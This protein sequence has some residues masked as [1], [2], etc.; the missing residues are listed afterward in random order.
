[1]C[2]VLLLSPLYLMETWGAKQNLAVRPVHPTTTKKSTIHHDK[3]KPHPQNHNHNTHN[4]ELVTLST[5][6]K[7]R[8]G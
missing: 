1:M 7:Y 3:H 6:N 8:S 4:I 5:P 2:T